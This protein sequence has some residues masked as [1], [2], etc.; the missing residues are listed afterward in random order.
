MRPGIPIS[1]LAQVLRDA[2]LLD[3]VSGPEDT[4]VTGVSHD[5][6]TIEPGDVFLAWKGYETDGHAYLEPARRAGAV[7]A[8]VERPLPEV[9]LPQ[10]VVRDGRHAAALV[11]DHL[12]GRPGSGLPLVGITGTNGKTTTALLLRSL[13]ARRFGGAA[14][15][16]TLG[17]VG[18]DGRVRP[19]TGGLTTPGP[20]ELARWLAELRDEGVGALTLEASSHALAQHRLDAL[21]FQVVVFTNLSRD[22]LDYH[23]SMAEYRDAKLRLRELLA[24]G[25]TVVVN[26]DEPSWNALRE[27]GALSFGTRGE[28]DVRAANVIATPRG[29]RFSLL[30][31]GDTRAVDLPLLGRFNVENA[32]AAAAAALALGLSLQEVAEGLGAAPQIPGRMEVVVGEPFTILIDFAHTPDA[33]ETLLGGLSA[34]GPRRLVVLFGAGGDRDRGKRHPMAEAVARYAD[35]VYLTSDNPRTE[36]PERILDDLQAGLGSV[37]CIR[38]PDR[39]AAIRRAVLDLDAG[40]LLV[41]AGK[42]H[43]TV[44]VVGS[45]RL[46]LDERLEVEAAMALRG[47]A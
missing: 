9:D 34:L 5:S 7:A 47:A 46:P 41:L 6:R 25:G 8:V 40:D 43:E 20:V 33:L 30:F 44:Q 12:F 18:P 31:R 2:R 3:G 23:G 45:E 29:S 16:G 13:L 24:E 11:A 1:E 38:E 17:V 28:G 26:A 35:R 37:E 14:A 21:R 42:G 27:G 15:L 19:G 36:D 10:L 32:L 39:R 4:L 22:H